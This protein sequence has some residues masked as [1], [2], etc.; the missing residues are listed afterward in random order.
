MT[1]L[2][3]LIKDLALILAAAGITTLIFKKL[4]QPMVLG[5]IIAGLFV[6]PNFKLFP[7]IIEMDSV[8]TWADIGVVFLLFA[9]GLEFSFKK[10]VRVGGSSTIT[11]VFEISVMFLLGY[12]TGKFFNW[13]DMDCIFL[14]GIICISSTTIIFRAFQEL[15]LMGKHFTELVMGVLVIEDVVAVVLLVLLS[16]VAV[17]REFEGIQMLWSV[18]K[19]FFFLCL[20]FLM[21]IFLLPTFFKRIKSLINNETLLIVA[22]GLCLCMVVFADSVGFSSALGAF[23]MGSLLAETTFGERIEHL[24]ASVKDLFGAIFFVSVGMLINPALLL[25]HIV[26]VVVLTLIVMIGKTLNVSIGALL[27]GQPLK[28]A[29]QAGTSMGQIGEF[30]FIIATLGVSLN[31]TSNYLYPVAVGVSVI[32]TFATPYMMMSAEPVYKLLERY[33]PKKWIKGLNRYSAGTQT[34]GGESNWKIVLQSYLKVITLNSVII[35]ALIFITDQVIMP[36]AYKYI[37]PMPAARVAAAVVSASAMTPFVWALMAKRLRGAA[38][39]SLWLNSKY[40]R[41]P[42]IMLEITRNALAVLFLMFFLDE[43]FSHSVAV[44]GAVVVIP[45][46]IIIFRNRIRLFYQR[47][48][49]R[50]ITNLNAKESLYNKQQELSPWD[51]HLVNFE[52]SANSA[53]TGISLE[54]LKWRENYGI[55]IAFIERGNKVI[56]TPTRFDIIFPFDKIGVIGTDEQIQKFRPLLDNNTDEELNTV[57][58][59]E[60]ISLEKIL[61]DQNTKLKGQTIRQSGIREKTHGLVVGIERDGER[62]LNPSSD[63]VFEWNDIIWIVGDKV[64]IKK[65]YK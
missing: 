40:N 39:T 23:I 21:G 28:Q 26:P 47:I 37:S 41:G 1:H 57:D 12:L 30:S 64:K 2:P 31:V 11:G 20:W 18:G 43:I 62:I 34:L 10:L 5:Y 3:Q 58:N 33:L 15:G 7:T 35:I 6:G 9:L 54:E 51:A 56:Y 8:K 19:L 29:V 32:T 4:K 65:L 24:I 59:T 63:I 22:L 55:N 13:P 36:S 48:E 16:T 53:Y 44:I 17:S 25:E 60:T 49:S 61:V 52:V 50:F 46:I 45:L 38:Y 42:L 14:G 27:A